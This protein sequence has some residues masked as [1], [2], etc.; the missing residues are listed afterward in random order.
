MCDT[1]NIC[2]SRFNDHLL[3]AKEHMGVLNPSQTPETADRTPTKYSAV[4]NVRS[5][6]RL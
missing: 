2:M 4:A 3:F 1:L 6:V 5:R